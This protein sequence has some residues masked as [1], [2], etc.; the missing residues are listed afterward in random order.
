[1]EMSYHMIIIFK[2]ESR[3][4]VENLYSQPLQ[5][6]IRGSN[7]LAYNEFILMLCNNLTHEVEQDNKKLIL[8]LIIKPIFHV[9]FNLKE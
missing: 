7:F 3:S 6:L 8:F 1:M 5:F 9:C 2:D 4:V